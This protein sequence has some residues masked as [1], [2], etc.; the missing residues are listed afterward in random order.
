MTLTHRYGPWALVT[1]ASS[2]IGR[3]TALE[4]GRAGLDLV[5]VA[6]RADRLAE[7][8]DALVAMGRRAHVLPLDLTA[9]DAVATLQENTAD[10][11]VGLVVHAAGFGI[12]GPHE[13]TPLDAHLAMLDLNVRTTLEIAYRF[14]PRLRARGRG[15][16]V[17]YASV[18][19]FTGVP[20]AAHYAATKAYV[21]SLAEGLD[22]E[23][24]C[25][26]LDVTAIAPGPTATEF[27]ERASM[28][29]G[30]TAT[31]EE[32]AHTTVRRLGRRSVVLPDRLGWTIRTSLWMAPRWLAVRIMGRIMG[33]MAAGSSA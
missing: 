32:V 16:L 14:Q 13:D 11:D 17:L 20:W 27:F 31:P 2:G 18:I 5:L 7:V 10:L 22:V 23:W 24:R 9:P 8:A 12:S 30:A 33:G 25:H 26:G 15:G 28:T 19:A 3:A 29:A 4:L 1:G 21:L 6:R